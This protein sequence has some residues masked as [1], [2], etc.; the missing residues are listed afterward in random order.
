MRREYIVIIAPTDKQ[1]LLYAPEYRAPLA[2]ASVSGNGAIQVHL[3]RKGLTVRPLGWLNLRDGSVVHCFLTGQ[4]TSS[5][6]WKTSLEVADNAR[7]DDARAF[8]AAL[9][10]VL[11]SGR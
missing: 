4:K 11:R 7:E 6:A 8:L 1:Y 9:G 2:P 5:E 3:S 10:V